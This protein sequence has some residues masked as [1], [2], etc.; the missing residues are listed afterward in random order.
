MTWRSSAHACLPRTTSNLGGVALKSFD[1]GRGQIWRH[2]TGLRRFIRRFDA[3]LV[4]VNSELWSLTSQEVLGLGVPVVVHGAE[5]V[6]HHGHRIEQRGRDA[7]V[8]RGAKRIVGYAS[9][10]SDGVEH[11]A[12]LRTR[13]G[14]P[15]IPQ[16]VLPAVIPPKEFRDACLATGSAED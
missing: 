16:L 12:D 9:W 5:N 3:D 13:L 4:H 14:L 10:N 7:L 1:F 8:R 15:E 11:V 6:W 2:L